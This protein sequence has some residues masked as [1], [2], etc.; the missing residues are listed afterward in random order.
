MAPNK[1][2]IFPSSDNSSSPVISS[3]DDDERTSLIPK[4][5]NRVVAATITE[6]NN[7]PRSIY[8]MKKNDQDVVEKVSTLSVVNPMIDTSIVCLFVV[9][10]DL[11]IGYQIEHQM[12][13]SANPINLNGIEYKCLPSGTHKLDT[14]TVLFRHVHDNREYFGLACVD[15]FRSKDLDRGSRIR[16]LGIL[17]PD[18]RGVMTHTT[19]LRNCIQ[20]M[21]ACDNSEDSRQF[22]HNLTEYFQNHDSNSKINQRRLS[23]ITKEEIENHLNFGSL[24]SLFYFYRENIFTLWKALLLKKRIL[25]STS[26]PIGSGCSKVH[27][28]HF[29]TYFAPQQAYSYIENH[30]GRNINFCYYISLNDYSHLLQM[31]SYLACTCDEIL[32]SKPEC[33]DVLL[34]DR[35][36]VIPDK[37]LK[38]TLK[39]S[40]SDEEKSKLLDTLLSQIAH[41]PRMEQEAIFRKYFA[42][43]NNQTILFLGSQDK[44]AQVNKRVMSAE[45]KSGTLPLWGDDIYF[46][47]ELAELIGLDI[48]FTT[49]SSF[50]CC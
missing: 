20:G 23:E 39:K 32:E 3:T 41:L 15:I 1:N 38:Q 17:S 7:S 31:K 11:K 21:N 45:R 26:V 16:S 18:Y 46:V 30:F 6:E 47:K 48:E 37:I 10:F 19:F 27:A 2:A 4:K 9:K 35:Q 29:L 28:I 50:C 36:V 14:D 8:R 34:K 5:K 43:I 33:Y 42:F 49:S 12:Q 25:I 40:E 22:I 13:N 44:R 24:I